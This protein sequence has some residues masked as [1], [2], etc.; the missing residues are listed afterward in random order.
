ME[1][2]CEKCESHEECI[3]VVCEDG[4]TVVC[5]IKHK[6][7]NRNDVCDKFKPKGKDSPSQ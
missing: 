4:F 2:C 6:H 7:V 1:K 5:E 3:C